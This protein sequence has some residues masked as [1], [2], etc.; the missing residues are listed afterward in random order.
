[1]T[2]LL[3]IILTCY[4]TIAFA[5]GCDRAAGLRKTNASGNAASTTGPSPPSPN[6]TR[7]DQDIVNKITEM[8]ETG[9]GRPI[10]FDG[11][12]Y[13]MPSSYFEFV[14]AHPS[15]ALS[16]LNRKLQAENGGTR[17][18]AYEFVVELYKSPSAKD[19]AQKL[20]DIG[21]R[22]P[23]KLVRDYVDTKYSPA[24]TKPKSP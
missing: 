22:D 9:E 23:S 6:T 11:P 17:L 18:N 4:L 2:S 13:E 20:L 24:T 7:L 12:R 1:M 15:E 21:M 19:D 14:R 16:V 10:R 8:I 5:A 3:Q